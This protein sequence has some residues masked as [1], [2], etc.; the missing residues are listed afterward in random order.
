[1]PSANYR[2]NKQKQYNVNPPALAEAGELLDSAKVKSDYRI[3][4]GK[5]VIEKVAQTMKRML[6]VESE[7]YVYQYNRLQGI[8]G[9]LKH[10][11]ESLS[12]D[13]NLIRLKRHR[14]D[15]EFYSNFESELE[16]VG[17]IRSATET[18]EFFESLRHHN[19]YHEWHF[20]LERKL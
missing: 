1:M 4:K 5:E 13:D 19:T 8:Y 3:V 20:P 7:D 17:R 6:S 11:D 2:E 9:A 18:I 16:Y 15:L 14:E 10:V 12:I